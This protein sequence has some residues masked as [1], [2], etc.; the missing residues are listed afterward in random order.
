MKNKNLTKLTN[1]RLKSSKKLLT[2]C[3]T[4]SSLV[5]AITFLAL[6]IAGVNFEY[7]IVPFILTLI[8]GAFLA[9]V[10]LSNFRFSYA[11][12]LPLYY[13]IFTV[14]GAVWTFV[15]NGIAEDVVIYTAL[16]SYVWLILHAFCVIAVLLSS[17]KAAKYGKNGK[18]FR[19]GA[20]LAALLL[21]VATGV[22]GYQSIQNGIFGQGPLM[23]VRALQYVF[24]E[25]EEYYRVVGLVKGRGNA[26]VIPD[27]F[28][29]EKVG[30]VD[31]VALNEKSVK[32][33]R[34]E[35][36]G[37]KLEN[38]EYLVTDKTANR[39]IY[40]EKEDCD[41][42]RKQFFTM[43]YEN[44][45]EAYLRIANAVEPVGLAENEVY[46]T[47]AY[48][49]DD[50][51]AVKGKTIDTWYGEKGQTI[52]FTA[53]ISEAEYAKK[54]DV[55]N[56]EHVY[57]SYDNLGKKIYKGVSA[58][59][60]TVDT[61][62]Q[63]NMKNL[64]VEFEP[65]YEVNVQADN[66]GR[67][68]LQNDFKF[69]EYGGATRAKI[70]TKATAD[71][72]LRSVEQRNGFTIAWKHSA[73]KTAFTSLAEILF[74]GVKIYPEWTMNAPTVE[75]VATDKQDGAI[76]GDTVAF[77][78]QAI[79][80]D[81]ALQLRYEW[82]K[83]GETVSSSQNWDFE[84]I[85][86]ADAGEYTLTVTAY[87]NTLTTLT[88]EAS[89]S[90][91]ISVG[92]KS[93][94]FTWALPDN[95]VYSGTIKTVSANYQTSDV[96]NLDVITFA[97]SL[98]S[99]K[100]VGE[101]QSKVTLTGDCADLYYIP[102]TDETVDFAITPFGLDVV[103]TNTHLTY[104][105]NLQQPTASATG[106]GEDGT[107]E[108]VVSG[109]KKDA[110]GTNETYT[111]TATLDDKNY[112][113]NNATQTF[114][115]EKATVDM[116]WKNTE[117]VY[118][119]VAQ[120]PTASA[121]GLGDDG[122]LA[123]I[124][125]GDQKNVGV[126]YTATVRLSTTHVKNYVISTETQSQIFSITK[127]QL[128][129]SW[130]NTSFT[131]NGFTQLPQA[132]AYGVGEEQNLE[133]VSGVVLS[134]GSVGDGVNVG[135]NHEAR[136][137]TENG[138]YEIVNP[139]QAF[140]INKATVS[141]VWSNTEFTYDGTA[142]IPTATVAGVG[143]DGALSV[144]VSGSRMQAGE[145]T[146][147]AALTGEWTGNYTLSSATVNQSFTVEKAAVTLVWQAEKTF[148]YDGAAKTVCVV[149][150]QGVVSTDN[151]SEILGGVRYETEAEGK[152]VG[153]YTRTAKLPDDGNYVIETGASCD[154]TITQREISFVWSEE[155][156]F[157][158][159]DDMQGKV[160]VTGIV[161]GIGS[162]E[163]D[164]EII[165]NVIYG[166]LEITAG[167]HIRTAALGNDAVSKNYKLSASERGCEYTVSQKAIT[168]VW[169]DTDL[170]YNGNAQG[171]TV[172]EAV[173][174]VG[175]DKATFT[176][177]AG[178]KNANEN[179]ES[180][181]RIAALAA[182]NS[183][184]KNYVIQ[185]GSET[186]DYSIAKHPISLGWNK[187]FTYNGG[188]QFATVSHVSGVIAGEEI[189][190]TYGVTDSVDAGGYTQSVSLAEDSSVN[191]NYR[192]IAG[193]ETQDYSIAKKQ[194]L[195]TWKDTSLTYNGGAQ[196]A[197]IASADGVITGEEVTFAYGVT[198]SVNAGE[199]T[200]TVE[201]ADDRATNK[202]YEILSGFKTREYVIA[203]KEITL[204]WKD[205]LFTYNGQ[206]QY[207]TV[208]SADG[209]ID[210]E[211]ITF[212]Y[213]VTD[214]VDAG[215]YTQTATTENGNYKIQNGA[216][217]FTI[218]AAENPEQ[219]ETQD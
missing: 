187:T 189:T 164:A 46:A 185:S 152:T 37:V 162:D 80:P 32:T 133:L 217:S 106:V 16:S 170:I 10:M 17:L 203:K 125:N 197:T 34:F 87:S 58:D 31:C 141:V 173:G 21:I 72:W 183:V 128:T 205:T 186:Q 85:H 60:V 122:V 68:E 35:N 9:A 83:D 204:V 109:A 14:A 132:G 218:A 61:S 131:Y 53:L 42:F 174:L 43:A 76:Y 1:E 36:A 161:N 144:T 115:I 156:A 214:S 165:K 151:H 200:Q 169:I 45:T 120:H 181:T 96:I 143:N 69:V 194:L 123:G 98:D 13:I 73:D 191:K 82:K 211:Q 70:V 104:N 207:A 27:E 171:A 127:Y 138:N 208:A 176:Y 90:T 140:K 209:V 57:W 160:I 19:F 89:C 129:V 178:E 166:A 67:Y 126:G 4:L 97:I 135:E 213:G 84:N 54:S 101:Y 56:P 107:L 142:R 78:A 148:V 219:N 65:L 5:N 55:N 100:D 139:T 2:V 113:L 92:K 153:E 119:G 212:I 49:F 12:W 77:S 33:V 75:S 114:I 111:A 158:Y 28:N 177:N 88:S 47:F 136:A 116:I 29:G 155:R 157:T 179:G 30:A 145:G 20:A 110:V 105:A 3:A 25:D 134:D 154:F 159:G 201:L 71:A 199:Y 15:S 94:G 137:L 216:Q 195:V 150:V 23:K 64:A 175:N 22:C 48:N 24:D 52:D 147:T 50:F 18:K 196:Y 188:K 124:V 62:L 26:V 180:Y 81:S 39:V 206:A 163:E 6:L 112:T 7:W 95:L 168:L 91:E 193:E 121:D 93:L 210:G 182:D 74:D 198:D 108:L 184:N 130:K 202:N 190:F 79:A 215:E 167:T 86:F 172:F 51:K 40:V 117:L 102:T 38:P 63:K 44:D 41:N 99:V 11:Q 118:K 66:D 103:W 59:G 192:I 8:D 149:E 146:A